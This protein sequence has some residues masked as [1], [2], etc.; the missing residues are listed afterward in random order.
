MAHSFT[1]LLVHLVFE[2]KGREPWLGASVLPQ[3]LRFLAGG[4][5]ELGGIPLEINGIADHVHILAKVRQDRALADVLREIKARSSGWIH[6]HFPDLRHFAWQKGY[7][8]FSVSHSQLGV[9]RAY[10]RN[11]EEHYRNKLFAV[12]FVQL[13]RAPEIEFDER[14]LWE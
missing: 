9:V 7:G 11:Q 6:N 2:T 1:N 13:L 4:V 10:I 3:V 12:E 14:C 5:S 8:A